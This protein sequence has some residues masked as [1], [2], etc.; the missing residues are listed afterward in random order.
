MKESSWCRRLVHGAEHGVPSPLP[1]SADRRRRQAH[2]LEPLDIT[3]VKDAIVDVRP[4]GVEGL[5]FTR[6]PRIY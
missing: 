2:I 1:P 4:V 3:I 6:R 5:P